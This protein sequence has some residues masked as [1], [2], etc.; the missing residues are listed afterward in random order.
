MTLTEQEVMKFRMTDVLIRLDAA[1][2]RD[3][4]VQR[5]LERVLSELERLKAEASDRQHVGVA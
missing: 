2:K 5:K 3:K 1:E 4:Y